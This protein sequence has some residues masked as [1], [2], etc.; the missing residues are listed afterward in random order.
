LPSIPG[1]PKFAGFTEI[2]YSILVLGYLLQTRIRRK[3]FNPKKI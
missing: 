3:Y 1:I 2:A